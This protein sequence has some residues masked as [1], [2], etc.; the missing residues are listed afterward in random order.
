MIGSDSF[1]KNVKAVRHS[2]TFPKTDGSLSL[3]VPAGTL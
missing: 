1:I 3:T 2:Q